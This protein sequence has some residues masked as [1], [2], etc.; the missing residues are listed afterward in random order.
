MAFIGMRVN[1]EGD[2]A[3]WLR[4]LG[5]NAMSQDLA[6]KRARKRCKL[7][8]GQCP[9]LGVETPQNAIQAATS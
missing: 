4:M 6:L 3:R 1:R 8:G 5:R 7:S 2:F 9:A